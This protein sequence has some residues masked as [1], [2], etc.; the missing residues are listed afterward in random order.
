MTDNM[1][2]ITYISLGL[3]FG[4]LISIIYQTFIKNKS[5]LLAKTALKQYLETQNQSLDKAFLQ[6]QSQRL[7]KF[8]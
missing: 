8:E 2:L 6:L 4:V 5:L 7:Q 3:F 1:F